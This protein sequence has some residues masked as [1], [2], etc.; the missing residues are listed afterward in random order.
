MQLEPSIFASIADAL[1]TDCQTIAQPEQL[2]P[3]GDWSTWLILAGRGASKTRAG[4]ALS[5][6]P[7][8]G[9]F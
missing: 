7:S 8:I 4:A 3:T 5:R 6:S 1:E 9:T 2:P